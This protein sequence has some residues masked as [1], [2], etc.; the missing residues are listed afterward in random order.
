METNVAAFF[1][2]YGTLGESN[3]DEHKVFAFCLRYCLA[4]LYQILSELVKH[5]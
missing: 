5:L 3:E 2:V 1:A 4:A